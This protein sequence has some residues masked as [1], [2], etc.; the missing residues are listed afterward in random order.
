MRQA[1][2]SLASGCTSTVVV[3]NLTDDPIAI[4]VSQSFPGSVADT[5]TIGNDERF[6]W[7][8]NSLVHTQVTA[9]DPNQ[10]AVIDGIE[11]LTGNGIFSQEFCVVWDGDTLVLE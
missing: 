11:A 6:E 1:L 5:Q 10:P 2:F 3:K 4:S 7:S 9:R 8:A